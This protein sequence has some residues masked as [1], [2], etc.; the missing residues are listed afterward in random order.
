MLQLKVCNRIYKN[1]NRDIRRGFY[2][3][4]NMA[5]E[6][7]LYMKYLVSAII[8]VALFG[9]GLYYVHNK[10]IVSLEQQSVSIFPS[11]PTVPATSTQNPVQTPPISHEQTGPLPSVSFD[12]TKVYTTSSKTDIAYANDGI[13]MHKLDL[14]TPHDAKKSHPFIVFIH[15]G[16]FITGDKKETKAWAQ[17]MAAHGFAVAT[18]NY[19]LQT[20]GAIW[21]E[22]LCDVRTATKYLV[23]NASTLGLDGTRFAIAGVSAGGILTA[24]ATLSAND[25]NLCGFVAPL[26]RGGAVSSGSFMKQDIPLFK[27]AELTMLSALLGCT[28]WADASCAP[29]LAVFLPETYADKNDPPILLLHGEKDTTV[30]TQNAYDFYPFLQS[31]GITVQLKLAPDLGHPELFDRFDTET[32]Q[33]FADVLFL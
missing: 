8:V 6:Y 7:T 25:A 11:T 13:L 4:K 28:S 32:V 19:R 9:G 16:G 26:P 10:E 1:K 20:Q 5:G 2:F 15:G 27:K 3:C 29:K 24:Q 31:K 23:D 17:K 12:M 14:Y 30:P 22:P 21:P 33:F 18:V